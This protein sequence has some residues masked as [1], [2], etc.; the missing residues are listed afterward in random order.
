MRKEIEWKGYP[1][2]WHRDFNGIS[3][4]RHIN[5]PCD[6]QTRL[7]WYGDKLCT[8]TSMRHCDDVHRS[9]R[10]DRKPPK[11]I[12]RSIVDPQA[13]LDPFL[14]AKGNQKNNWE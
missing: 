14:N 5:H 6:C 10:Q 1:C 3:N 4:I 13:S 11:G 7:H 2:L 12:P 9:V 8:C